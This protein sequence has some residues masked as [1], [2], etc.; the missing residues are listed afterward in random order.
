[1]HRTTISLFTLAVLLACGPSSQ[2]IKTARNAVY[3]CSYEQV[4]DVVTERM[5]E[6]FGPLAV[7]NS[8][9]GIVMGQGRW[10]EASGAR[11]KAGAA[12]VAEGDLLFNVAALVIRGEGGMRVQAKAMVSSHVV[13]SPHGQEL[14]P[15]HADWP[16]WADDR[17]DTLL[18]DIYK[19]LDS[20]TQNAA[21]S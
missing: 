19:Q 8:G 5:N 7:A 18:V 10:H 13:G 20:C 21:E 1:M 12:I 9:D 14:A 15:G 2:E 3:S 6:R 4:F 17:V 16:S 11:K